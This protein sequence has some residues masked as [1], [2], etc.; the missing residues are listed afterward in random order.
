[1]TSEADVPRSLGEMELAVE[2]EGREWMGHQL[3]EKLQSRG[4][5]MVL[6][7]FSGNVRRVVE[8][9]VG[10]EIHYAACSRV[11]S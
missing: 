10:G 2:A 11:S 5:S 6:T 3:E 8:N 9:A 1:M 4:Q 7:D